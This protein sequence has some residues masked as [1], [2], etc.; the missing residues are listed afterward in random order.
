MSPGF[1][2]QWWVTV[3]CSHNVYEWETFGIRF[4]SL[5]SLAQGSDLWCWRLTLPV[6][7]VCLSA[8]HLLVCC[9][10]FSSEIHT[11]TGNAEK[12]SHV[13]LTV[14]AVVCY[15]YLSADFNNYFWF[16]TDC[17]PS[18]PSSS[19]WDTI[20]IIIFYFAQHNQALIQSHTAGYQAKYTTWLWH[21]PLWVRAYHIFIL[22]RKERMH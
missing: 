16:S 2:K 8:T 13:I 9:C 6:F 18:D 21:T 11:H 1:K 3:Y 17:S 10:T 20:R 19:D 15:L 14:S 7:P 12:C 4:T 5:S 22:R